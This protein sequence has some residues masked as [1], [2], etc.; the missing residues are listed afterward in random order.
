M[1]F[2]YTEERCLKWEPTRLSLL[3]AVWSVLVPVLFQPG[4][5]KRR[6]YLLVPVTCRFDGVP[7]VPWQ[8]VQVWSL[9]VVDADQAP[10]VLPPW[11]EVLVHLPLSAPEVLYEV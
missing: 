1:F 6:L 9:L 4:A 8:W 3:L 11:Q 5:K 7:V 10:R 2:M